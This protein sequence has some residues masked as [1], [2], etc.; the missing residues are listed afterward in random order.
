MW[1]CGKTKAPACASPASQLL[2]CIFS[3]DVIFLAW[4]PLKSA[5]TSLMCM[6]IAVHRHARAHMHSTQCTH[7]VALMLMSQHWAAQNPR[8]VKKMPG[9]NAVQQNIPQFNVSQ[10]LKTRA[11]IASQF[12]KSPLFHP[13]LL[14]VTEFSG[15]QHKHGASHPPSHQYGLAFLAHTSDFFRFY[16][17]ASWCD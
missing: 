4:R 9:G 15:L 14:T 16:Q 13:R 2:A 17:L 1:L 8:E 5:G 10:S 12:R 11:V 6:H 7:H 3:A